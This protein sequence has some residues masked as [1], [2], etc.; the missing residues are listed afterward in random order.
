MF[1]FHYFKPAAFRRSMPGAGIKTQSSTSVT[2]CEMQFDFSNAAVAQVVEWP[3]TVSDVKSSDYLQATHSLCRQYEGVCLLRSR[4]DI[5]ALQLITGLSNRHKIHSDINL[6]A[7]GL[8]G[9]HGQSQDQTD[10]QPQVSD[11]Q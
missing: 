4:A 11:F 5:K 8:W 10:A 3:L 6:R 1:T 2:F 7:F 9:G